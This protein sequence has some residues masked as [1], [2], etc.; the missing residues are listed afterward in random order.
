LFLEFIVAEPLRILLAD[1]NPMI[2]DAVKRMLHKDFLI[3]GALKDSASVI[4]ETP[5]LNPDVL[6]LDIS[7][8]DL[9]GF[10]IARELKAKQCLCKIIFLTVH[11]EFEFIRAALAVGASG[12]VFKSR[13]DT[14]LRAALEAVRVGKV[15]IPQSPI[16]Q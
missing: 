6:I 7:M 10:E 14:D 2:L 12:Y 13:M 5:D 11:E 16:A 15:F 8:D 3:V 9:N 4:H 1:D